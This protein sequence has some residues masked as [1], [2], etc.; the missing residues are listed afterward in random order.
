[1][2]AQQQCVAC[3]VLC[4]VEEQDHTVVTAGK[5]LAGH[6]HWP[7]PQQVVGQQK[8]KRKNGRNGQGVTIAFL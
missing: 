6:V 1:L 7:P 8:G 4:G 3:V 5:T 2:E